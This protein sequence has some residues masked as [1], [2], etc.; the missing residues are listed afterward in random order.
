MKYL[1][2]ILA[3]F[4]VGCATKKSIHKGPIPV[5]SNQQLLN[6]LVKRN[7]DFE[8]FHGKMSTRISSPDEN[9]SG[10][11]VVRM[12]KD[13][14]IW[15]AVKKFGIEAARVLVDQNEYTV[16]Y[17]LEGY[18]ETNPVSKINEIFS[19]ATNFEDAQQLMFG[20]VI[21]PDS[22]QVKVTQDSVY[23]VMD[24][25]VDDLLMKYYIHAYTLE[26]ERMTITDKANRQVTAYFSDYREVA[27]FGKVAFDRRFNFP[28]E[29]QGQAN[30][31]LKFSEIEINVPKEI[32]FSIPSSYERLY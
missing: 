27:G 19:V 26:L 8:W 23:Y 24:A 17:R 11:M 15:V 7:I 18:Y 10:S 20:N 25:K 13:S 9:I 2:L 12:K 6:A 31:E 1:S 28:Y 14:I 21:L 22:S 5:R 30:I 16:L 32:K 4:L 29:S 3:I